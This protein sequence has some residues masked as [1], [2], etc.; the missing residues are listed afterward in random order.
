VNEL[1]VRHPILVITLLAAV[2]LQIDELSTWDSGSRQRLAHAFAYVVATHG[3]DLMYGGKHCAPA[4][5]ALARG[6]A[7]LAYLPG[8]ITFAGH[9]WCVGSGHMGIRHGGGPCDAELDRERT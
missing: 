9:H 3:D 7:C 1:E 5:R 8:G 6:L 4:F 2:P